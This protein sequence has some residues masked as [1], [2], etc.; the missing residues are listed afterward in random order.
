M[1][2]AVVENFFVPEVQ[3]YIKCTCDKM[4]FNHSECLLL[5]PCRFLKDFQFSGITLA[6][7]LGNECV[8]SPDTEE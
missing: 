2:I 8:K 1:L 7:V 6:S 5:V 4:L 3:L